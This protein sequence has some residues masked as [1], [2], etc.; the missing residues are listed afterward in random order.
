LP[1]SAPADRTDPPQADTHSFV[2]RVWIEETC[3]TSGTARWRGSIK[4]V[5]SG[6]TRYFEDLQDMC[7]FVT[8]YMEA[9]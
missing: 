8:S 2:L 6:R 5:P 1:E 4:H 3:R 9:S 7:A